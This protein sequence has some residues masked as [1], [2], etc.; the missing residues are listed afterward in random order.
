MHTVYSLLFQSEG[1]IHYRFQLKWHQYTDA[2]HNRQMS[3]ANF[4]TNQ[5]A[6]AADGAQHVGGC[7]H[8][9]QAGTIWPPS[10][11][12]CSPT[13][14]LAYGVAYRLLQIRRR[15]MQS[16]TASSKP[17]AL[18]ASKGGSF[19]SWLMRIVVSTCYDRVARSSAGAPMAS[20]S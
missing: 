2:G 17:A 18:T 20:M 15:R 3:R 16:R 11:S 1:G 7:T 9:A 6:A 19:K 12:W 8:R 4:P 13:Q 5:D 10:T 14:N